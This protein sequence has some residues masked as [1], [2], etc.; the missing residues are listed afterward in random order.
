MML[1]TGRTEAR[2]AHSRRHISR[3]EQPIKQNNETQSNGDEHY[4]TL[5]HDDD[6]C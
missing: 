1:Y 6:V 3:S 4:N 2:Q 5:Y